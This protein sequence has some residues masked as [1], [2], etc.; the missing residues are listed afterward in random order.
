[1]SFSE[2]LEKLKGGDKLTRKGWNGKNQYIELAIGISYYTGESEKP[3]Y[4]YHD[5]INSQAIVFV[6]T[7][8]SQIGWLASQADMLADDWEIYHG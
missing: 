1:M 2:A 5:D 7:R 4:V 3:H 6:G 8:G